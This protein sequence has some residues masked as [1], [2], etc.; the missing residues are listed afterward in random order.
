M[1]TK[2]LKVRNTQSYNTDKKYKISNIEKKCY[3][4]TQAKES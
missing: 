3:K 4:Y 2:K 1:Q